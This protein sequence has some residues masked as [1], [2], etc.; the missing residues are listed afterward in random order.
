MMLDG[1]SSL[2]SSSRA[3]LLDEE[4]PVE[5]GDE[6]FSRQE[7]LLACRVA[8]SKGLRKSELLPRFLLYVCEQYLLGRADQITEQQ[9]GIRI[10]NRPEDYNPGEDNI[11]RSYARMLRKRL[12]QYFEGEGRHESMRI[13]I[14]RGGY[15][16]V[17]QSRSE[18]Q[19]GNPEPSC[20]LN[21]APSSKRTAVPSTRK[22]EGMSSYS[23]RPVA[24]TQVLL[25]FL[26]GALLT[27]MAWMAIHWA[28]SKTNQ[29]A[30]HAVWTEMFQQ[31]RNTLIVASDSGLGILENL[32]GHLV[33]VEE[34]ANGTYLSDLRSPPGIDPESLNDLRR[35]RYTSVVSLGITSALIQLPEFIPNRAQ[36][37]YARNI[38]AED[39]KNANTILIGSEH[40]NPWVSLFQTRVHAGGG[41][42][43]CPE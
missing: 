18:V 41:Q 11:V 15:I 6:S 23:R 35:Q 21:E 13:R 19:E 32:S 38:T 8:A 2:A 43:L 40:T 1:A 39:V 7:W 22:H 5:V 27:G 28:Q 34:Y 10:F 30:A 3:G 25:S 4:V 33:S 9:I 36:V 31:N 42:V 20:L 26:A 17:F 29:G 12:D 37:R 16:P 14:P 24:W